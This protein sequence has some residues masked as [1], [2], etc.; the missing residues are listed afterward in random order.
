MGHFSV[1]LSK[2]LSLKAISGFF[3]LKKLSFWMGKS[4]EVTF[5]ASAG[6]TFRWASSSSSYLAAAGSPLYSI[7]DR[8]K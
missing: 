6:D 7:H 4:A 8:T 3:G 5:R 2:I 1:P